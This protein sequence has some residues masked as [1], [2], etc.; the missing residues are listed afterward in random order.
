[1]D[2]PALIALNEHIEPGLYDIERDVTVIGR[3]EEMC[4]IVIPHTQVSR[5]HATVERKGVYC[6]LQDAN[7]ANGTYVNGR[8]IREPYLLRN[9][10]MIGLG[11]GP[12]LLRFDDAD[13]TERLVPHVYYDEGTM[14]FFLNEEPLDLTPNEFRLFYHLYM[15]IGE[16]CLHKGCAEAVWEEKYDPDDPDTDIVEGLQKL[17]TRIRRKLADIDPEARE[18]LVTRHGMGYQLG[19]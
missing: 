18:V 13:V 17:V 6:Y 12:A 15:H 2:L 14:R 11:P 7:S 10:D 8:R 3:S 1:M 4:H 5:I 19:L 9:Q 16:L